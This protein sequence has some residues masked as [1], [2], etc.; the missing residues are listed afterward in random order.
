MKRSPGLLIALMLA[1]I[2]PLSTHAQGTPPAG[3]VAFV[4]VDTAGSASLFVMDLASGKIGQI[5]VPVAAETD[6]AWNPDGDMLAF[7]TED[8]GYGLLRSLRGCFDATAICADTLE[9]LTPFVTQELEW[10]PDGEMLYFL[11]DEGLK[12]SPPRA[13][14][15]E[16][17]DLDLTC[18]YGITISRKPFFLF[19]ANGDTAGNIQASVYQVSASTITRLYDV[20]TFP[21]V[22]R[23][24]VGPDG[25]SVV[26]TL[27]TAG[28]SGF[29][30]PASGTPA[31]LA[32]YQIH[33]YDLAF[34]PDGTQIAIVGATAD[35]TGD[36]TLRDGDAAELYLYDPATGQLKQ[37]PGFT[38][39][40]AVT[41]ST[42]GI[43]VL[44]IVKNQTFRIFSSI[45]GQITPV[46]ALL[47]QAGLQASRPAWSPAAQ[48][49][50]PPVQLATATS[51]PSPTVAATLTPLPTLTPFPT[52]AAF[53]TLTPFPTV[54]PGSPIGIGCQYAH[55]NVNPVAVGDTAE[56]TQYGAAVRFRT[57]A[58]LSASMIA[59]LMP[60]TRL[61]ILSGP[62]CADGYRWW[63]AKLETDGRMGYLADSDPDGYW[64]QKV[65]AAPPPPPA[66]SIYF[67]ADR[68]SIKSG[69]CVTIR[70]DVEG[71]KEVYFEGTGVVGHDSR[72][73][74]PTNTTIY[75]LHIVR[76]DN[77]DLYQQV[78][79]VVT[80]P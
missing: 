14:P 23:F 43:Y 29:Y 8:G 41:W 64:I 70:W 25:R 51:I 31:R 39:A 15:N 36:G 11:T 28:D 4:G 47:P 71:I 53:P 30:A 75:T 45:T 40:T 3:V 24:D 22:T 18:T 46:N 16:I 12:V 56:V 5:V 33:V 37:T 32:T 55:T 34:K 72:S 77:S 38:N 67:Y 68:Y 63:Q 66:E 44:T 35:S 52:V 73:V 61:T 13:R 78:T 42:D 20:G 26:G 6:L 9:V 2:F 60:G 80:P 79:I 62:Y 7:T 76:L 74:C 50:I 69:K 10:S 54:T 1:L 59:E 17:T 21:Q 58:A 65:A 19:C 57:Q 49:V 48:P 27:E